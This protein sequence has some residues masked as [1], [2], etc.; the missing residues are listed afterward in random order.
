MI[1]YSAPLCIGLSHSVPTIRRQCATRNRTQ[2]AEWTRAS[3]CFLDVK[4]SVGCLRKFERRRKHIVADA[5]AYLENIAGVCGSRWFHWSLHCS[6]TMAD[7]TI[8]TTVYH[9]S[10]SCRRRCLAHRLN[11]AVELPLV[12]FSVKLLGKSTHNELRLLR[13]RLDNLNNTLYLQ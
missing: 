4:I 2:A 7:I 1:G 13:G 8:V 5:V 10:W 3:T 6:L 12:K 9:T 11:I